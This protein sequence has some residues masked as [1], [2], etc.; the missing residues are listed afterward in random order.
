MHHAAPSAEPLIRLGAFLEVFALM[1]L[2]EAL[3]PRRRQSIGR[4]T[5]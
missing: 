1:A 4:G 5:R 3:A 2:W